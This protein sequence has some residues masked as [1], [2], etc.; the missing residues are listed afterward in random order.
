MLFLLRY[1]AVLFDVSDTLIEYRPN[2]AQIYGD[3]LRRIG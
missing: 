1:D 2:Y 3:R